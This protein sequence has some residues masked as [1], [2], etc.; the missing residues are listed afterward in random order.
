MAQPCI[1]FMHLLDK[2]GV[3]FNCLDKLSIK[4][5][6]L[7][8]LT[9]ISGKRTAFDLEKSVSGNRVKIYSDKNYPTG[10]YSIKFDSKLT[11]NTLEVIIK[12]VNI[13]KTAGLKMRLPAS[14]YLFANYMYSKTVSYDSQTEIIKGPAGARLNVF[15]IDE[16]ENIGYSDMYEIVL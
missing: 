4:R 7:M 1:F 3:L 12:R 8:Q 14:S 15:V 16:Y 6:W 10:G 11:G 2:L 9:R 5:V 13:Q